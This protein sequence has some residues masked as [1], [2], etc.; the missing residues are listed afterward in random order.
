MNKIRLAHTDF[1]GYYIHLSRVSTT[2]LGTSV[3][4]QIF[5][6]SFRSGIDFSAFHVPHYNYDCG[7]V[8]MKTGATVGV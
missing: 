1:T 3:R 2:C 7:R 8:H 5:H 6:V 4:A